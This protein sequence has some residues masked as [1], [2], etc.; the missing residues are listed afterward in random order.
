MYHI[1]KNATEVSAILYREQQYT[2]SMKHIVWVPAAQLRPNSTIQIPISLS[3][4]I[5]V[6]SATLLFFPRLFCPCTCFN[7]IS[8]E[9]GHSQHPSLIIKDS[10]NHFSKQNHKANR[11]VLG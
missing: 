10:R 3:W 1:I 7:Y 6:C 2:R 5:G 8:L 11:R 4:T 9:T